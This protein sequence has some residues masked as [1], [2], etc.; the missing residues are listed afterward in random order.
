MARVGFH[1]LGSA[2]TNDRLARVRE[3]LRRGETVYLAGLG[4]PIIPASRWSR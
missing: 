4:L 1:Q 3:K 2:F